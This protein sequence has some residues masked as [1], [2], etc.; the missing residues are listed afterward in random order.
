M[1]RRTVWG[2]AFY[3]C[4]GVGALVRPA[5][6]PRVFGGRAETPSSRTEIRAVYGGL[7]LAM[8][9][10]VALE[11]RQPDRPMTRAVATLSLAMAAGRTAGV[12]AERRIDAPTAAFGALEVATGIALAPRT[13]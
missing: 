8:A 11:A 7:P 3:A 10:L 9:A 12:L 13:R 4:V 1:Q 6:V 5:M 2:L